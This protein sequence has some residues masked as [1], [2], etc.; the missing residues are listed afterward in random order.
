MNVSEG[1]D[2]ELLIE[3]WDLRISLSDKWINFFNIC[4]FTVP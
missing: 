4:F 1:V 3:K 2:E